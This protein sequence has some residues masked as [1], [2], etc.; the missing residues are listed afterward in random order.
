MFC[1]SRYDRLLDPSDYLDKQTISVGLD[2]RYTIC[3]LIF[4]PHAVMK[5]RLTD[6]F[7]EF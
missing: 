1:N 3:E 7:N 6:Q 2:M 4:G 5:D